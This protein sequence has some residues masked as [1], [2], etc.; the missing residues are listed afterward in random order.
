MSFFNK[1]SE[2]KI[3]QKVITS[4]LLDEEK[5]TAFRKILLSEDQS[6]CIQSFLLS[7]P[8][9]SSRPGNLH[10]FNRSFLPVDI[11]ILCI[12]LVFK[13]WKTSETNVQNFVAFLS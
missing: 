9:Y 5:R 10:N 12:R 4:T 1:I 13:T 3:Q 2:M 11:D 7:M 8:I 6:S